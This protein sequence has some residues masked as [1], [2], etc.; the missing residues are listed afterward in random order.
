MSTRKTKV[1]PPKSPPTAGQD[2]RAQAEALGADLQDGF[3]VLISGLPRRIL[4]P[5]ALSDTLEGINVV[6]ASRLLKALAQKDPIATLQLLPG[7]K[8]LQRVIDSAKALGLGEDL[9]DAAE[10]AT[11]NF[12]LFI[13][14]QTGDR[15]SLKAMLSAWLPEERKEFEKQRRQTIFKARQELEG[16]SSELEL[17]SII[18]H[19]SK[20]EGHLDLVNVK[21][22]FGI[23]RI[24]P[25]AVVKLGTRRMPGAA[26]TRTIKKGE[27]ADRLP[28][29]L[30]GEPA[31]DGLHSVLLNEFC[32]ARPAPLQ[33]HQHGPDV[34][35]SLG[36][37]GFGKA[38]KVDLVITEVNR[39]EM[40]AETEDQKRSPHFW[41][42]PEM[43]VRKLVFDL[44][45]HEDVYQGRSPQLYFYN[46]NGA[47]PAAAADPHREL[48]RREF[49][50]SIEVI[51][52][53]LR[54]MRLMEFPA[55]GKLKSK[56]FEKLE[57]DAS[58]FR[59][60]RISITYP[61]TGIQVSLAFHPPS[62]E[63][64]GGQL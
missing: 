43:C 19:P 61:L 29:N 13:R 40:K 1:V 26:N 60:Y 3:S 21:C 39:G 55:Y 53:D 9:T 2:L 11:A 57:W 33:V 28:T 35:Y 22:L 34:H 31:Q 8:P 15:S 7:P 62:E 51:G 37:T 14:E 17:N 4:G 5:Q 36:P 63:P 30:D 10:L 48:D 47:G 41:V 20:E 38:S 56:I 49:T 32:S 45:L 46:T 58:K 12:D 6:S 25:D 52:K 42:V 59:A 23:D 50:H 24:R 64:T 44:L 27:S 16:V 18:L 54:R